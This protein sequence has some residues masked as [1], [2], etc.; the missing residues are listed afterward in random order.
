MEGGQ[1]WYESVFFDPLTEIPLEN[2]EVF[3]F[4]KNLKQDNASQ[5]FKN[6]KKFTVIFIKYKS[7][8]TNI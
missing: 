4:K 7:F 8:Y 5:F 3:A 2:D 1:I 6:K